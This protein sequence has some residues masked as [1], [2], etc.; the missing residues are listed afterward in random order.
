MKTVLH[1]VGNRPQFIKLAILYKELLTV[2][3]ISQEII[4]TGQHSSIEMSDIFFSE[5]QLPEPDYYL[6]IQNNGN[7]ESF[8]A[9]ASRSLQE[10]FI[11]HPDRI[12][13]VYGDTNTTF[14]AALAAART[15]LPLFHIEAGIRTGDSSMPEEINRVLTDRL[16]SRN[17]CCTSKNYSSLVTE[18]YGTAINCQPVLTG[19]LMYD[20]FLKIP[21]DEKNIIK[22]GN[23]IATTIHRAGNILSEKKLTAIVI[24]LNKIH[25]EIP[26]VMPVHPHTKKRL[27]DFKISPEF[28]LLDPLGYRSM[29]TLLANCNYVITD[30][31]GA[32]REAFFNK[33]RSIVVM[34]K[35]FWPEIIGARCGLNTSAEVSNLYDAFCKLP[36]LEGNFEI[37]LFGDGNAAQK[38]KEDILVFLSSN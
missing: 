19:D 20:A 11:S 37:K 10:Y 8:I 4:H 35:P 14:A 18:G 23:Y 31:G 29:K 25:K 33:K 13:I 30:S 3:K 38:I 5:L 7:T 24:A 21:L 17:Y 34:E 16:A 1:I 15:G 27:A 36:S 6:R 26:V 28:I 22:T 32:A 9:E 12:V 2:N